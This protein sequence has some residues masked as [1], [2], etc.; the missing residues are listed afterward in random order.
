MHAPRESGEAG[1]VGAIRLASAVPACPATHFCPP[2]PAWCEPSSPGC[3]QGAGSSGPCLQRLFQP[4]LTRVRARPCYP[5]YRMRDLIFNCLQ[6]QKATAFS[7]GFRQEPEPQPLP[8]GGV[9]EETGG[10]TQPPLQGLGLP[11]ASG[12]LLGTHRP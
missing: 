1:V 12:V 3:G 7:L 10:A 9:G 4:W 5:P 2:G 8:W 11:A 6:L